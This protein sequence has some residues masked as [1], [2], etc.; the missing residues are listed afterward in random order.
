MVLY[1]EH[2]LVHNLYL[3][4]LVLHKNDLLYLIIVPFIIIIYIYFKVSYVYNMNPKEIWS[5]Y[6]KN[7]TPEKN[8]KPKIVI[9][10]I[11]KENG[12][13]LINTYD[14]FFNRFIKLNELIFDY[15]LK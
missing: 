14:N 12:K 4:F 7:Y 15:R 5:C 1:N 11:D 13:V 2:L 9:Q 10:I 3:F 8:F 6:H